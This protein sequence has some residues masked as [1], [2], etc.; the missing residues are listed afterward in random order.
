[1]LT[2]ANI[3]VLEVFPLVWSRIPVVWDVWRFVAASAVL[4]VSNEPAPS[5]FQR[6]WRMLLILFKMKATFS[7][8]TSGS[9]YTATE[10]Y[11][12]EDRNPQL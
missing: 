9:T 3:Q 12:P 4:E 7:V 10:R 5:R 2:V 1:M 6:A 8:E 11:A